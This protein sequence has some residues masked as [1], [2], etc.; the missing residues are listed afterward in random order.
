MYRAPSNAA[1]ATRVPNRAPAGIHSFVVPTAEERSRYVSIGL[2]ARG[3][4]GDVELGLRQSGSFKRLVA[5]KRLRAEHR[6][7]ASFRAMFLEEAKIAG[8]IRHPHVVAV[9]DV[10]EDESGPFLVMDYV[11]GVNVS[12]VLKKLSKDGELLPVQVS[13]RVAQQVALG[14]A[15]AH[16]LTHSDGSSLGLVHRDVSPQNILLGLDGVARLTDFGIAKALGSHKNTTA[17]LLKGKVGYMSPEQ[18]RFEHPSQRSDFFSLGVVL[19]ELLS[20]KRLYAGADTVSVAQRVLGEPA[21]DIYA[22]RD[23]VPPSIVELSFELLAKDPT[24]RPESAR[25]IARRIGLAIEELAAAEGALDLEEFLGARFRDECTSMRTKTELLVREWDTATSRS[26]APPARRSRW[27]IAAAAT[28]IV[29]F[30]VVMVAAFATSGASPA[31]AKVVVARSIETAAVR[32]PP[33][34]EPGIR[35]AVEHRAEP[36]VEV[37]PA[38]ESRTKRRARPAAMKRDDSFR[39]LELIRGTM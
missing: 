31:R 36:A 1:I 29:V 26:P 24:Q 15:A 13:L 23:D 35:V 19:Y 8:M 18:L 4:M 9:L 39:A 2:L 14:L 30:G 27:V 28:A 5:I 25:E 17:G 16:G 20:G 38:R 34:E 32:E 7:D 11:E 10:G 21:P 33:A 37:E 6:D 12:Q 22:V 3:G